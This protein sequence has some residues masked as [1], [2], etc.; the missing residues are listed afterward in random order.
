MQKKTDSHVVISID[1]AGTVRIS[2]TTDQVTVFASLSNNAIES[3]DQVCFTV[4]ADRLKSIISWMP[5]GDINA[6]INETV[7][8]FSSGKTRREI[9]VSDSSNITSEI[10]IDDDTIDQIPICDLDAFETGLRFAGS[11]KHKDQQRNIGYVHLSLDGNLANIIGT[12]AL[13]MGFYI[14]RQKIKFPKRDIMIGD[15]QLNAMLSVIKDSKSCIL[16]IDDS[17]RFGIKGKS[18]SMIGLQPMLTPAPSIS[19]LDRV[20]PR[21]PDG[22][23]T[24]NAMNAIVDKDY[25]KRILSHCNSIFGK[26]ENPSV[27]MVMSTD[28]V[29]V[30]AKSSAKGYDSV[31]E[32]LLAVCKDD[33]KFVLSPVLLQKAISNYDGAIEICW[34][35]DSDNTVPIV[36]SQPSDNV[37]SFVVVSRNIVKAEDD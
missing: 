34:K 15:N 17:G 23:R 12:D 32:E 16:F 36:V 1:K 37:N 4:Q 26:N 13:T 8:V 33:K 6:K 2:A 29:E 18:I 22:F 35:K 7:L 30:D 3:N 31:H 27:S 25:L 28:K 24:K 19:L 14:Y 11:F 20:S 21:K 5:D 9:S 10:S